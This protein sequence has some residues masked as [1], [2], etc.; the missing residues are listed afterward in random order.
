M[1]E[2]LTVLGTRPEII[3]LSRVILK[4]NKIYGDDHK[5]V[6]T[7]QNSTEELKDVF[8]KELGLPSPDYD[9][10]YTGGSGLS[11]SF[12]SIFKTVENAI[13]YEKP[14]KMLILGDTNSALS[15]IIAK[16]YGIK[17]YHMEAGNRCYDDNVPEEVNRRIVDT[18][19]DIHLPYTERS[20][21]N[22][23]KEGYKHN[24]IYVTGNPIWEVIKPL[25][26]NGY[27]GDDSV[28][29]RL[30]DTIGNLYNTK[31][32]IANHYDAS[33][34]MGKYVMFSKNYILATIHRTENVDD[35]NILL[36]I[37]NSLAYIS[38]KENIPVVMSAHPRFYDN[39]IRSGIKT[40]AD[41][42]MFEP[43][44]LSEFIQLEKNARFVMSDSG[45]VQE[46][47]CI[48]GT[49]TITV[50]EVTERPET[51]E[52]GRNIR[53]LTTAYDILKSRCDY[54]WNIPDGYK[55][56]NVSDTVVNILQSV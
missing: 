6:Y 22:L 15:S 14:K 50:R 3:R 42:Y 28:F 8:F 1:C 54:T 38:K 34:D 17:V 47:C 11:E 37:I 23:I 2:I 29:K 7:G 25:A 39:L 55:S 5:V 21:I 9:N 40:G 51:L 43:F 41:I 18:T 19:S 30:Y 32:S 12:N 49:P 27:M 4:L 52:C 31:Y 48:L 33:E 44:G 35:H 26:F 20:R 24:N 16:R 45:T 53:K 46:E 13:K 10:S 56:E 36:N